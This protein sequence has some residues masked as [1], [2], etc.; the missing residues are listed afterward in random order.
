MDKL[1]PILSQFKL[2]SSPQKAQSIG[3]GHIHD[4]Y[5][6]KT[7]G[8]NA[9]ILQRINHQIFPDVPLLSRNMELVCEQLQLWEQTKG[10]DAKP[11]LTLIKTHD[12]EAYFSHEGAYWR[13]FE[14]IP[15]SESHEVLSSPQQAAEA[16]S[17]FGDFVMAMQDLPIDQI[18]APIDRFHDLSWRWQQLQAAI[19]RSH[20]DRL[21]LAQKALKNANYLWHQLQPLLQI[22]PQLPLRILHNDTKLTNVLFDKKSQKACCVIDLDTVM[23][24]YVLYDLGDMLR[25]MTSPVAEDSPDIATVF[26]RME[27]AEAII[28]AY[29]GACGEILTEVEKGSLAKAGLYM[30]SMQAIRFLTDFLE[31]DHYYHT[32]YPHHNL[33]RC[34][35]QFAL[36]FD[37]IKKEAEL[38]KMIR[39]F[40]QS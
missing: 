23:P 27:Y 7:N 37:F 25:S 31:G 14:A 11:A 38:S 15:H 21:A 5:L 12:G 32:T 28:K 39:P 22:L 9:Y 13:L 19:P 3:S 35:N 36:A 30:S 18:K 26:C 6:I 29:L 24:G 17:R 10:G 4:S 8:P 40:T 20:Q 34:Q 1:I 2:Q 16:A 33:H